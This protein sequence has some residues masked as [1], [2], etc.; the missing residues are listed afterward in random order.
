MFYFCD[1]KIKK[2]P[3]MKKFV[4]ILL[5]ICIVALIYI[6]YGSIM[7]PIRFENEKKIR[8]K[9]VIQTLMDIKAAQ[10]EYKYQHD[11]YCDNFDSLAE[12]IKTAQLP[13]TKK[14]GELT[15]DQLE[16][17]WTETKV[18]TLY[19]KA[20]SAEQEAA[21][22]TGR[23][24]AQKQYE[25]DTLWQRA[26]TEG[27]IEIREDGS[28]NFLFSRE[29]E[30]VSL[31]DSLYKGRINPDSLRYVPFSNG[32]EFELSIAIDSAKT[33]VVNHSFEAKTLFVTYLGPESEDGGLDKQEIINLLEDCDDRGRYRG[34]KV[35]NNSGNWE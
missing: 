33:G 20:R 26:A 21:K 15:D 32:K 5:A 2:H 13:I 12:F 23:R 25:A 35:D 7:N 28:K 24:A 9:A 31:Y 14:I 1:A 11:S 30:F 16:N 4:N 17:N 29:T 3:N 27:F 22:L 6:V 8:D 10:T 34:M 18:L 19:A